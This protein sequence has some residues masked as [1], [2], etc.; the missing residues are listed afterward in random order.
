MILKDE[1]DTSGASFLDNEEP[2]KA[3]Y[4]KFR[5]IVSNN[6]I[7]INADVN[8]AYQIMKKVFTNV[9]SDGIQGVAFQPVRVSVA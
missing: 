8:G 6:G 2:V 3:N 4:N 9:T 7:K 5:R 1:K